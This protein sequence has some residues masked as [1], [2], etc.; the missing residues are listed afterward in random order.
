MRLS[1]STLNQFNDCKKCFYQDKILKTPRLRGIFSSL[2]NGMDAIFKKEVNLKR[3]AG[4]VAF[5]NEKGKHKYFN[6]QDLIKKWQHWASGLKWEDGEGNEMIGALDDVLVNEHGLLVP[7]DFKTKGT[8]SSKEYIEKYYQLNMDIYA[9]LLSTHAPT[10]DYAIVESCSPKEIKGNQ[11]EFLRESF[12]IETDLRRAKFTFAQALL[13]LKSDVMPPASR[14]CE[15]CS[16]VAKINAL[17][18]ATNQI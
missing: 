8:E 13:T 3:S 16:Y 18:V 11:V 12:V 2:P 9:L 10:A 6:D 4:E 5:E 1:A 15:Y 14:N 7:F 17:Q